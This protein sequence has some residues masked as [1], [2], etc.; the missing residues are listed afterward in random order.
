MNLLFKTH[1]KSDNFAI[2]ENYTLNNYHYST[3]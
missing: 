3:I 2:K 1:N